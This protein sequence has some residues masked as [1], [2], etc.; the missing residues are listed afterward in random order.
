M[1]I[2]NSLEKEFMLMFAQEGESGLVK[3][4][5]KRVQKQMVNKE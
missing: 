2:Y 1:H 4:M 5:K 3:M